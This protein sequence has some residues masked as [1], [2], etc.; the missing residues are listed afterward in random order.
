MSLPVKA[1]KDDSLAK[2]AP[3]F[4]PEQVDLI[5]RTVARGTTDDELTLFL[6]QCNRTD[7]DPLAKQIYAIKR[8]DRSLGR[9]VM[10]IQTGIDGY[11]L[12]AERTGKTNGQD[13]P[14]W[15][16]GDGIWKDVWLEKD[17]PSA[18][19]VIIYKKGCERPYTGIALYTAY[20]QKKAG[21]DP[22]IFWSRDPAGQLAKCAEAL[23]LRKSFPQELSGVYTHEEMGQASNPIETEV[24]EAPEVEDGPPPA[25]A[26]EVESPPPPPKETKLTAAR[27]AFYKAMDTYKEKLG[28]EEYYAI[29]KVFGKAKK[30][31]VITAGEAK[32]V[33]AA[34]ERAAKHKEEQSA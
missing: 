13:G 12:I 16:G 21:G 4:S 11:R 19:K 3:R 14:F 22:N 29:L 15:C 20:V 31:E 34:M 23:G 2:L 17:P 32:K 7:L 8:F 18:A 26:P 10:T 9:E 24:V 6:Y 1:K 33:V 30:S 25:D 27:L 5:K 28:E